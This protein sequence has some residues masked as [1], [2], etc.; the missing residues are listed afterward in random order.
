[1]LRSWIFQRSPRYAAPVTLEEAQAK[2][3][4]LFDGIASAEAEDVS[5]VEVGRREMEAGTATDA[6]LFVAMTPPGFPIPALL[7]FGL[8]RLLARR[9]Q[10]RPSS[11][12]SAA[13]MT[14]ICSCP[15][16]GREATVSAAGSHPR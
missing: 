4:A 2:A 6:N 1:M 16:R 10:R 11:C 12:T 9:V 3:R 15:E 7:F 8:T 14:R 5:L 13:R